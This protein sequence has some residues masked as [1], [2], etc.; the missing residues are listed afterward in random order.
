[1]VWPSFILVIAVVGFAVAAIAAICMQFSG[2]SSRLVGYSLAL[3]MALG[4]VSVGTLLVLD[5]TSADEE[6]KSLM[7]LLLTGK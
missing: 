2:N 5:Q 6:E 7:V 3:G 1:M 4:V